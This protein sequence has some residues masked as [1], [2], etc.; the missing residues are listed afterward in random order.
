MLRHAAMQIQYQASVLGRE[1]KL[2]QRCEVGPLLCQAVKEPPEVSRLGPV[3][4]TIGSQADQQAM[5]CKHV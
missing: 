2:W 5:P 1:V 3:V 4:A